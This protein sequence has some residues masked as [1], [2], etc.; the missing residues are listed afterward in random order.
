MHALIL[1][2]VVASFSPVATIPPLH[3]MVSFFPY[4]EQPVIDMDAPIPITIP[5]ATVS[6]SAV[7]AAL[8]ERSDTHV[9]PSLDWIGPDSTVRR[10]FAGPDAMS[11][12]SLAGQGSIPRYLLEGLGPILR[13]AMGSE[14]R[15]VGIGSPIS[16]GSRSSLRGPRQII[17]HLRKVGVM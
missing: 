16:R 10:A 12:R 7:E 1:L 11:R 8:L 14:P 2:V 6:R 15:A 17:H 9:I 5:S 4:R 13:P 3:G